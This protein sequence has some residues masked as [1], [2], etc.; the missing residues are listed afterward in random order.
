MEEK[1]R[2][3]LLKSIYEQHWLH[4][5]HLET[6]R[7]WFTSVF[8]VVIG[9]ALKESTQVLILNNLPCCYHFAAAILAVV[10]SII[11]CFLMIT[12]RAPFVEHTT[13]AKEMLEKTFQNEPELAKYIPYRSEEFQELKWMWK[14]EIKKRGETKEEKDKIF[15]LHLFSAFQ[16]YYFIFTLSGTAGCFTL[17]M[18]I[19]TLIRKTEFWWIAVI[20]TTIVFVLFLILLFKY[21][22]KEQRYYQS[23]QQQK[24]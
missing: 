14:K 7:F 4:A 5:R 3:E 6:E 17:F 8:V 24:V 18:L 9:F 13:L 12:W 22:G 19:F 20:L 23:H 10:L 1:V 11:G 2:Q 21:E 16:L 15:E